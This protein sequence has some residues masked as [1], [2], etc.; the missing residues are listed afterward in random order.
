MNPSP[1][2]PNFENMLTIGDKISIKN[3]VVLAPMEDVSDL[4]FRLICKQFGADIV[5]TEFVASDAIVRNVRKSYSKME[6]GEA[7]RPVAIQIFGNDPDVMRGAAL[8]AQ[9]LNPDFLDIN[10]GCPAKKVAGRGAGSG[11]LCTPNLMDDITRAVVEALSIPVTAKTR[12]G[13]DSES[14]SIIE[15]A[16]RMQDL[17]I[18][19]LTIHGRT[20]AQMFDGSADWNWIKK[21]K[22]SVSMPIIGNGDITTPEIGLQM[23][24]FSKVD[25]IM[26]GR[27]AYGNPWIFKRTK[28]LLDTGIL[29]PEPEIEEKVEVM[30][31]HLRLCIEI[32]GS[33]GLVTFRK[34]YANYLKGFTNAAK[35]R[36]QLITLTEF[37]QIAETTH[38]FLGIK[39]AV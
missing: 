10:Y 25:G 28:H 17:G 19:A 20:R 32:K 12:I 24:D 30:L 23:F 8:R 11:L 35:L 39:T 14:I 16:Q 3:A 34:H 9:A 21:A 13:W 7:E 18:K 27:G 22:E 31:Q 37:D 36:S 26:I 2:I 15:T 1:D 38:N 4:P 33:H 5:Y 6:L 29:L